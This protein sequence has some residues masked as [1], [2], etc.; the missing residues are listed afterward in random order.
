ME[1][2]NPNI[3]HQNNNI[4]DN[5]IVDDNF[6]NE[7]NKDVSKENINENIIDTTSNVISDSKEIEP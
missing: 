3:E 5:N 4:I 1:K 7:L 6:H 2:S